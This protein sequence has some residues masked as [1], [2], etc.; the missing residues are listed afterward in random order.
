MEIT[1]ANIDKLDSLGFIVVDN[2]AHY[3]NDDFCI[4]IVADEYGH[5]TRIYK[6]EEFNTKHQ[7]NYVPVVLLPKLMELINLGIDIT[8]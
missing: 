7:I 4:E 1:I 3:N 2:E 6:Y 8:W 5:C